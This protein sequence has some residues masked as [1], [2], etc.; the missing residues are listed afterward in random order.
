[1]RNIFSVPSWG[2]LPAAIVLTLSVLL[3]SCSTPRATYTPPDPYPKNVSKIFN[4]P[5]DK[6][7]ESMFGLLAYRGADIT[8]MNP[9]GVVMFN[10][11]GDP[12]KYIDCGRTSA[13][14]V[15]RSQLNRLEARVGIMLGD[16][17]RER[18]TFAEVTVRYTITGADGK[19]VQF[20]SNQIG[21]FANSDIICRSNYRMETD[22]LMLIAASLD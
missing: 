9:G 18:S 5:K 1:M 17:E 8:Y 20:S 2:R 16:Q 10:F 15:A 3:S 6:V 21:R 19:T 13:G 4:H 12:E 11:Q 22:V 7:Y 14:I